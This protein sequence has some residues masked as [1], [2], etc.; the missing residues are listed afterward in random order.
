LIQAWPTPHSRRKCKWGRKKF[1]KLKSQITVDL[2][3]MY[4]GSG[5]RPLILR[6]GLGAGT[7]KML[8]NQI[9]PDR[10]RQPSL[11]SSKPAV[12]ASQRP[13]LFILDC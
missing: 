10:V 12:L 4:L 3:K 1:L 11:T 13:A 2:S 8:G 9:C 6:W 5:L 7:V